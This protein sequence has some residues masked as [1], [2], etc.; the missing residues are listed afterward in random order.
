MQLFQNQV[1]TSWTILLIKRSSQATV[2]L[3]LHY[4]IS[5]A[6]YLKNQKLRES[7]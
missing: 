1:K 7:S 2:I 6:I 5:F 3:L 4:P